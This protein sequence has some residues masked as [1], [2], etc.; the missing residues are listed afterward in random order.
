MSALGTGNHAAA[1]TQCFMG[2]TTPVHL[3]ILTTTEG[4]TDPH[5]P[6]PQV[7]MVPRV[8]GYTDI[9]PERQGV[10]FGQTDYFKYIIN[11]NECLESVTLCVKLDGLTAGAGGSNPRYPDDVLCHAIEKVTF[12]YGKDLQVLEGDELH[13]RRI[14]ETDEKELA[15]LGRLQGLGLDRLERANLARGPCWYYLEIPFWWARD[16]STSWH[17][18]AFQRLTRIIIQW[19]QVEGILQQDG[20]NTKPTPTAGGPYI[21]DHFLRF[22]VACLTEAAKKEFVSRVSGMGNTGWLYLIG[23]PERLVQQLNAGQRQHI[24]QLNT[25]SKFAYNLRFVVRP[26]ANLTPNYLNNKRFEYVDIETVAMDI[27]GRRY[28]FPSDRHWLKY[29][30]NDKLFSGNPEQPIY[31]IPLGSE[32]PQEHTAAKGGFDL[33]CA[34]TPQITLTTATLPTNHQIDFYSYAHNYVRLIIKGI[35]TGAELVQPL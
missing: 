8:T 25:F 24:I 10:D 21:L 30:I 5:L 11:D 20:A 26:V 17:Q 7:T 34:S 27:G 19:R 3:P 1:N 31:N 29:Q 2:L 4:T 33:S 22:K 35:E 15:R 16:Q 6:L 28:L 32:Y 18:Y 12:H 13:M 23:E 14:Q 9:P